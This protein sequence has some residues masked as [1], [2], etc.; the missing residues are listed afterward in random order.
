[1]DQ[2]TGSQLTGEI[3]TDG[4]TFVECTIEKADLI[5]RGGDHPMFERC[6]F[7]PDVNWRFLGPALTTVQFLQRIANDRGGENFIGRLFAK[8]VYFAE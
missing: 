5:Y 1:M 6:V 2:V 8:G 4:R 7:G 3:E